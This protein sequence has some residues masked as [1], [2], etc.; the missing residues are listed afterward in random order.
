M[1]KGLWLSAVFL[2]MLGTP[3]LAS[4]LGGIPELIQ[5]N[6]TGVL[7]E[8]LTVECMKRQIEELYK[9]EEKVGKMSYKC[10]KNRENLV[11]IDKYCE[12]LLDIYRDKV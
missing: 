11:T 10:L 9:S 3:V 2:L 7:L 12:F 8:E 1:K 5:E 4:R 6:E